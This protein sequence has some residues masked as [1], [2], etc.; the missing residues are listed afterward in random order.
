VGG[1]PARMSVE[2]LEQTWDELYGWFNYGGAR[3]TP[4]ADPPNLSFHHLSTVDAPGP[5]WMSIDITDAVN[6]WLA[7]PTTNHGILLRPLDNNNNFNDFVS[8]DAAESNAQFRPKLVLQI[9]DF[10]I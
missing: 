1:G 7:N 5:G 10:L 3:G 8:S 9:D 2:Q 4:T 6:G